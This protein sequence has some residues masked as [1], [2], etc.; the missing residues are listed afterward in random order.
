MARR[1]RVAMMV[2]NLGATPLAQNGINPQRSATSSV[3]FC[4][5]AA[6][7]SMRRIAG[8]WCVGETFQLGILIWSRMRVS[9]YFA[10]E[11][12]SRSPPN[13]IIARRQRST[14]VLLASLNAQT[15]L[16]F[17]SRAHGRFCK[18]LVTDMAC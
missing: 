8:T 16:I 7:S 11:S 4:P 10:L 5:S 17:H 12:F 6:P 18:R 3:P 9:L 2:P 14:C 1:S 13:F 15:F